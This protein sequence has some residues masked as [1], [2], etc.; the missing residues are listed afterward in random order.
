[1]DVVVSHVNA[2]YDSLGGLVGARLLEAAAWLL[3][4]GGEL[5]VVAELTRHTLNP[6][7]RRLLRDLLE[8]V[9]ILEIRGVPVAVAA[10]RE[11]GYVDE[12]AA[13]V[14]RLLETVDAQAAL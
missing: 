6:A 2:D 11:E 5:E 8:N 14:H 10:T 13:V 12:A 9:R 7:Q 1:M 4:A 3:E